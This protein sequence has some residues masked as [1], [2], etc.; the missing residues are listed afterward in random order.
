MPLTANR[1][2]QELVNLVAALGG[3]WHGAT[4]MCR[5]PAH[6]DTTPSLSI[7]QG[8]HGILVTCFAGCRR[9]DV[10]ATLRTIRVLGPAPA[11]DWRPPTGCGQ[12][13][14]LWSSAGTACNRLPLAYL[15]HR[16]F[17]EVPPDVRFT[18]RCPLGPQ[19][20]TVFKPALLVAVRRGNQLV[21]VQRIVLD[22][23]RQRATAK[24]ML[25]RPFDGAW[26][27][28]AGGVTLALA[29][30]FETA[31][32]FF[33]LHR[34]PC[35]ASLGARRLDLLT[36]PASVTTL[37]I[38]ADNDPEGRRAAEL[39]SVRYARPDLSIEHALPPARFDDWAAV[40]AQARERGG[41]ARR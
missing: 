34:I 32:A 37:V 25:G 21:A 27:G 18:P 33:Q 39:A 23:V 41:G 8:D 22:P 11:P 3:R 26:R 40:L 29:E 38:A 14:R 19:P 35:W 4:A 12:V 9:E 2:G 17:D 24:L 36:I 13:E 5:C 28:R 6:A 31:E 7:R 20:R 30:G 10:L 1:P 15:A 16:G